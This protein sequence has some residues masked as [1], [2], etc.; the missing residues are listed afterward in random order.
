MHKS[1]TEHGRTIYCVADYSGFVLEVGSTSRSMDIKATVG[2]GGD[3]LGWN[4]A[5]DGDGS[6]Y[7]GGG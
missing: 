2:A 5:G 3:K 6:R 4:T 7:G 1:D